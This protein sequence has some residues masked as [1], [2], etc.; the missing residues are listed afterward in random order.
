MPLLHLGSALF[1]RDMVLTCVSTRAGVLRTEIQPS[2][3][4]VTIVGDV[5]ARVLV[6]K[7]SKVGK[8]AEVLPTPSENGKR[9]EEGGAKD[10][11][12]RPAPAE[13]EK[14][15][16]IKDD[17]KGTGGDK[18][19]ASA[20]KEEECKKCTKKAA[21]ACDADG[22][23]GDHEASGKEGAASK[24]ADANAKGGDADGFGGKAPAPAPQVQVQQ[25]YHR[26]EPAMV[27]PV[28]VP[29]YYP[30]APAPYYGG[31]YAMPPPP[32]VIPVPM[33]VPR[34]LRP[35]P[36]RFNEDFFNDDNTVDCR[37]M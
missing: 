16:K 7:L 37:V 26:A 5:D 19:A 35:Q 32:M 29:A 25:H 21:R 28:H 15:S 11:S 8:I 33:G 34:Q 18:A 2:H 14:S 27:V 17:G 23:S 22:G 3:D 4:R 31:Y 9:R 6:K 1:P 24:D 10:V 12:D 30:P 20:C 36:S 13:E